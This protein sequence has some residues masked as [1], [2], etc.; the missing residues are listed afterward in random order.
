VG[1]DYNVH[2]KKVDRFAK[3]MFG[4]FCC[5]LVKKE[6]FDEKM[7]ADSIFFVMSRKQLVTDYQMKYKE[8]FYSL[9]PLEFVPSNFNKVAP[10]EAFQQKFNVKDQHGNMYTTRGDRLN[11]AM[12]KF[13][14]G[15]FKNKLAVE[16]EK[17]HTKIK[18]PMG[19]IAEESIENDK[20]EFAEEMQMHALKQATNLLKFNK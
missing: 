4:C 10:S 17:R 8:K 18:M 15:K 1:H 7:D 2:R 9:D 12:T 5:C 6:N 20:N 11:I 14:P 13:K 19:T 3:K 16:V